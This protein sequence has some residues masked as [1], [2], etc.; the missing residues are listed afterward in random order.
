MMCK[1]CSSIIHQQSFTEEEKKEIIRKRIQ[2]NIERYGVDNAAKASTAKEKRKQTTVVKREKKKVEK[3]ITKK[4][5]V[6]VK[7]AQMYQC[8]NL[9]FNSKQLLAIWL[10]ANDL[11][12]D[13]KKEPIISKYDHDRDPQYYFP[14]F[15]LDG[16]L[17]KIKDVN[18]VEEVPNTVVQWGEE[19]IQPI[20][21]YL[22][23]KYGEGYLDAFKKVV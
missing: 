3:Q 18:N 22:E 1:S 14:D 15:E 19:E 13:I 16:A 12:K 20:I 2:T 6:K 7:S 5:K 21:A 23:N 9:T 4:L 11:G 10:W 17:I 8:G